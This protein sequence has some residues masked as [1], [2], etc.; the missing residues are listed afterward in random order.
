MKRK[1]V[2]LGTKA[3]LNF[4][5]FSNLIA[6]L[7]SLVNYVII[8]QWLS[9][10]LM[11][12]QSYFHT[13]KFNLGDYDLGDLGLD[14]SLGDLGLG[15][16]NL[17]DFNLG[18]F[19]LIPKFCHM[20]CHFLNWKKYSVISLEPVLF[21]NLAREVK[22]SFKFLS[23]QVFS[24]LSAAAKYRHTRGSFFLDFDQISFFIDLLNKNNPFSFSF[25][26]CFQ[27]V[28]VCS[29]FTDYRFLNLGM[30]FV[31]N[32]CNLPKNSASFGQ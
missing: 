24:F 6:I 21:Q 20:A 30:N 11:L 27:K 23:F 31:M 16:F 28:L 19:D 9:H 25:I 32:N 12:N 5:P 26:I 18:D 3:N 14:F 2:R 4:Q 13:I 8:F 29:Q 22:A 7:H 1:A 10:L 17:G 15:D